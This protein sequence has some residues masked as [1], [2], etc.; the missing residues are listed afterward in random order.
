[1]ER[2]RVLS[3]TFG[4]WGMAKRWDPFTAASR[5]P[6]LS[7]IEF[8]VAPTRNNNTR[9]TRHKTIL[10][11]VVDSEEDIFLIV[12]GEAPLSASGA[13]VER[14]MFLRRELARGVT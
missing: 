4:V 13:R 8:G 5:T 1:M 3:W 7:H 12:L 6:Q 10:V 11:A 9:P 2:E 14:S